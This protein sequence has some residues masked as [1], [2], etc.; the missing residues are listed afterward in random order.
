MGEREREK[1]A[2]AYASG[3]AQTGQSGP[4][5]RREKPAHTGGRE[6]KNEREREREKAARHFRKYN[7]NFFNS[8]PLGSCAPGVEPAAL[9]SDLDPVMLA[10]P[11]FSSCSFVTHS[12]PKHRF[13]T[14]CSIC[15]LGVP[16]VSGWPGRLRGGLSVAPGVGASRPRVGFT[17]FWALWGVQRALTWGP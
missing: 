8:A 1:G 15:F 13:F 7:S 6:N 12:Y 11:L 3:P 5:R 4:D 10:M 9:T 17:R 2:A 14:H 16:G